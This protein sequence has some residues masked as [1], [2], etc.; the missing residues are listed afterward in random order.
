[1]NALLRHPLVLILFFLF[2]LLGSFGL[3]GC[4][5]AAPRVTQTGS[6]GEVWVEGH[7]STGLEIDGVFNP[8]G[9]LDRSPFLGHFFPG[10]RLMMENAAS[11][12]SDNGFPQV[13]VAVRNTGRERQRLQYRF[14]WF[15]ANGMEIS[16]G[17]SGWVSETLEPREVR[18][19]EGVARSPEVSGFKLFVRQYQPQR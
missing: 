10:T 9:T 19:L 2:F 1:M 6:P 8:D 7:F 17:Q 15:D 11:V 12:R 5:S 3:L 13:Q 18:T 14:L 4:Q 16:Q